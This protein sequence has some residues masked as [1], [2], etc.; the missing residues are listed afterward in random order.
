MDDSHELIIPDKN[1]KVEQL[2]NYSKDEIVLVDSEIWSHFDQTNRAA[3]LT[4]ETVYKKLRSFG[5]KSSTRARRT[6]G[7]LFSNY[8]FE[9][10]A[11]GIERRYF[12][13]G[14]AK[15]DANKEPEKN[16]AFLMST[17]ATKDGHLAVQFYFSI[18]G[19]LKSVGLTKSEFIFPVSASST[20]D[21]AD[22]WGHTKPVLTTISKPGNDDRHIYNGTFADA[23]VSSAIDQGRRVAFEVIGS[24]DQRHYALLMSVMRDGEE[25]SP[26]VEVSC[27]L[28][29]E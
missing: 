21:L 25:K 28:N 8:R 20:P 5:E 19:G 29:P 18:L 24:T 7:L 3:L 15:I 1:C 27:S 2:A 22:L 23:L 12:K 9:F 11:S 6:V 26:D 10:Y 4:H 17:T 16:S 14:T 13:C